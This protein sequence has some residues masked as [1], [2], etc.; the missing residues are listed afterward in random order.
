[1][2]S[3]H[4]SCWGVPIK[5][6]GLAILMRSHTIF[7]QIKNLLGEI[8]GLVIDLIDLLFG[9]LATTFGGE[10]AQSKTND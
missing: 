1:M 9:F 6:N 4:L 10:E 7:Y 2:L 8:E 5:I 3:S